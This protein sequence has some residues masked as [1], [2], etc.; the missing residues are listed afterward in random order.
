[1]QLSLNHRYP[2]AKIDRL[3]FVMCPLVAQLIIGFFSF[4]LVAVIYSTNEENTHR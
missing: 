3:S 4:L 1:V 2:I